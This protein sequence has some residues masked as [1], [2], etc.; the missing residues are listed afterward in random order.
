M[1]KTNIGIFLIFVG[2]LGLVF[3]F[4]PG[5]VLILLGINHMRD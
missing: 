5:I 4:V 1:Q 3:P 2:I